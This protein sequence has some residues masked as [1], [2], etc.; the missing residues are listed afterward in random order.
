MHLFYT[1]ERPYKCD[2]CDVSYAYPNILKKHK[3]SVHLGL[4]PDVCQ[5]CDKRFVNKSQ[6]SDHLTTHSSVRSFECEQCNKRFK[7]KSILRTHKKRVHQLQIRSHVC[8]V[9][10][11]RFMVAAEL[12]KHSITHTGMYFFFK[13]YRLF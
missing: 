11:K 13:F 6:L 8:P 7:R 3:K 12:R 2:Q 5:I 10:D 9:C 4:R 1:G